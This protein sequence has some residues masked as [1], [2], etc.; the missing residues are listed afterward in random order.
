MSL[1]LQNL[2]EMRN[3]SGHSPFPSVI[4]P[5]CLSQPVVVDWSQRKKEGLT[6]AAKGHQQLVASRAVSV[7][8]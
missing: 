6:L 1:R 2:C 3:L 8:R 5:F 7:R 4:L